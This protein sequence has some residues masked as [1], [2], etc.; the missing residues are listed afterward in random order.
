MNNGKFK[1]HDVHHL[2]LTSELARGLRIREIHT[3]WMGNCYQ[4]DYKYTTKAGSMWIIRLDFQESLKENELPKV[5]AIFTSDQNAK[6]VIE[7]NWVEGKAFSLLINPKEMMSYVIDFKP[8]EY[9]SL[10]DVKYCGE[11]NF[12]ECQAKR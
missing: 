3:L 2:N 7:A 11:D 5:N 10:K 12:Y 4:L 6:G 9:L 1:Y 8:I